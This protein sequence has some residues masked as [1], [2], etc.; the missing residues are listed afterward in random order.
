MCEVDGFDLP[1]RPRRPPLQQEFEEFWA[2]MLSRLD[3]QVGLEA[4]A[5]SN[6][7]KKDD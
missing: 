6:Q 1:R 3:Q 7:G 5:P 2:Q 4:D